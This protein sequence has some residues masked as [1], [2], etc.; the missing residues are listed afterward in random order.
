MLSS[1]IEQHL[2]QHESEE[3]ILNYSSAM[4]PLSSYNSPRELPPQKSHSILAQKNIFE[5]R[6]NLDPALYGQMDR[7]RENSTSQVKRRAQKGIID[8]GILGKS[9][10][11]TS[12]QK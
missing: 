7:V 6:R 3:E 11:L 2:A 8:R 12:S 9:V 10:D 5:V 4:G 1:E